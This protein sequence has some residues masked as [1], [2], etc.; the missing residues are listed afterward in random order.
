MNW[1]T[2]LRTRGLMGIIGASV[3]L[4]VAAP[5]WAITISPVIVDQPMDPGSSLHGSIHVINDTDGEQT[6]YVSVQNFLPQGENGGQQFLPA[7]D[8]SGL[9]GW[10][11]FDQTK[12]DLAKGESAN[13]P[14]TI[15]VPTGA[16]P[17]GHYAAVFF[18]TQP[19]DQTQTGVG[20][21]AKTGVL[22]LVNVSGNVSEAAS[23]ESFNVVDDPQVDNPKP[24]AFLTHL[25]ANFE[26]RVKNSGSVHLQPEGQIEVKNIFGADSA[27]LPANPLG[28]R[29]LPSSIRRIFSGWGHTNS[30][31]T[32]MV[33]ELQN[34]IG[35]FAF[36]RYTAHAMLTYGTSKRPLD[37]TVTFWVIPW[38]LILIALIVIVLL[39]LLL[40]GYNQMV[41]RGAM[42]KKGSA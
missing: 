20:V 16:E 24:T 14:W 9:A 25:P 11:R 33:A 37:A 4:L 21:G 40:K 38:E 7:T 18:S 32:G 34:E 35:N 26:L 17:G 19:S 12:V 36:G 27:E 15:L 10:F 1:L 42:K 23:V 30:T 28:S 6:Y 8:T 31:S 3:L 13:F 39:V 5:A 22:F 41:I 29:V 2:R